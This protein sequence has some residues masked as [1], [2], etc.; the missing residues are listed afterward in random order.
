M[1]QRPE[2]ENLRNAAR[3][4]RC[5]SRAMIRL[6]ESAMVMARERVLFTWWS[7][8]IQTAWPCQEAP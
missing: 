4:F 6:S 7:R 5:R 3:I 8:A 1:T 2:P